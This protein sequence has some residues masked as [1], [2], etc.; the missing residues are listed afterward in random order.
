MTLAAIIV[1]NLVLLACLALGSMFGG[2]FPVRWWFLRLGLV[3]LL[4]FGLL[5]YIYLTASPVPQDYDPAVQG[6]PGRTNFIAAM[7]YGLVLPVAWLAIA[8]PISLAYAIW[9][10]R[11]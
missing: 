9:K 2:R 5:L 11:R 8:V 7:A 1:P 10:T 3:P 6:N 4:C